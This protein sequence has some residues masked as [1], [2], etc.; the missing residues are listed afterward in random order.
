FCFMGLKK[1]EIDGLSGPYWKQ[2]VFLFGNRKRLCFQQ[3]ARC[4][5]FF[6]R[7]RRR[8]R[9][10]LPRRLFDRFLVSRSEENCL[11]TDSKVA[12]GACGGILR[13]RAACPQ[14]FGIS[15]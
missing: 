9:R 12:T 5:A 8:A 14:S 11:S 15:D 4:P 3:Y 7:L 6:T 10:N 1:K 13:R 2:A